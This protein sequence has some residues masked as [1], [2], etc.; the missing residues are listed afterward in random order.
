MTNDQVN[1]PNHYQHPSGVEC[2]EITR[3]MNFCLGNAIKYIWRCDQKGQPITDLKKAITYLNCEIT[4]RIDEAN[5]TKSA[6]PTSPA[7][8]ESS[9]TDNSG[10]ETDFVTKT[11]TE[12]EIME[13]VWG[14]PFDG[15]TEKITKRDEGEDHETTKLRLK[16]AHD[17]IR[18]AVDAFET[19]N[20][21][22]EGDCGSTDMHECLKDFLPIPTNPKPQTHITND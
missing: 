19:V 15:V 16:M 8:E 11:M 10:N 18:L 22:D 1:H 20:M 9:A 14:Q 13:L 3:H 17:A 21:W 6:S 12:N 5:T 2:I 4:R 7:T